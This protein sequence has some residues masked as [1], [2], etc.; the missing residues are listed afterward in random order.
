MNNTIYGEENLYVEMDS[1]KTE[2]DP[3]IDDNVDGESATPAVEHTS[4]ILTCGPGTLKKRQASAE[5]ENA[6]QRDKV[7]VW[8]ILSFTSAVAVVAVVAAT[9]ALLL[10]ITAMK[11]RNDSIAKVQGKDN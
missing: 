8:R 9:A 4:F 5:L 6:C 11:S 2:T 10:A 3:R 1:V 7:V